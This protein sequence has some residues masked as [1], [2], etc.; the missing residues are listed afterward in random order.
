MKPLQPPTA[1]TWLL[2]KLGC[3]NDALKGDLMEHYRLGR[4]IAW[5]WR[6]VLCAIALGF[7]REVNAHKLLALRAIVAG[8]A[9]IYLLDH[10]VGIAFWRWYGRLLWQDNAD[11]SGPLLHVA[12]TVTSFPLYFSGFLKRSQKAV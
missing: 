8:W 12:L 6:Q 2:D 5:Y 1:A 9:A 7:S 4:S 11:H 3:P 10:T